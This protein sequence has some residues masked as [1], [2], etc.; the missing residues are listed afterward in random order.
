MS[1]TLPGFFFTYA[2]QLEQHETVVGLLTDVP[3]MF[4]LGLF[5]ASRKNEIKK[6]YFKSVSCIIR[7]ATNGNYF[8]FL[9]RTP[10]NKS[11]SRR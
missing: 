1:L 9:S 7:K 2:D 3:P 5:E 10:N 6:M 4:S 8:Q 11:A